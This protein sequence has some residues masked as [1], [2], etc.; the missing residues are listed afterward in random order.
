MPAQNKEKFWAPEKK[1]ETNF[2]KARLCFVSFEAKPS[3]FRFQVESKKI[4]KKEELPR[5]RFFPFLQ[6]FF[7]SFWPVSVFVR[8]CVCACV[9][10]CVCACVCVCVRERE[11]ALTHTL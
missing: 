5:L 4:R 6:R 7:Q 11:K 8:A 10:V 2:L 9:R 3:C 1:N